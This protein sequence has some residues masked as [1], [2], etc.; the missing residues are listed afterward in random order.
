MIVLIDGYNLLKK[1][2]DGEFI[3]DQQRHAFIQQMQRYSKKK[4]HKLVIVFDGGPVDWG[5]TET[6]GNMIVAYSGR[7]TA[8]DY[9]KQYIQK[10]KGKE[11]VVISGDRELISFAHTHD[12]I[13]V[14]PLIFYDY[15]KR[16]LGREQLVLPT[17]QRAQK[18]HE[19]V[20]PALDA[21]MQEASRYIPKKDDEPIARRQPDRKLSKKERKRL[22]ILEK[23]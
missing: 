13:A 8:D 21:L 17:E 23:L 6:I 12:I 11:V 2:Y 5:S 19:Q 3:S 1:L 22:Q 18:L 9:I 4:K 20:E 15:V 7:E 14:E 16:A 10:K